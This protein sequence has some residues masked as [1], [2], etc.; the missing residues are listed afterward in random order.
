MSVDNIEK[1]YKYFDILESAKDKID[2]H[3]AE[4][5]AILE[6]VKGEQKEKRLAS[7]FI[8]RLFK[9]FPMYADMALG[10]QLN[11]CS[12]TDV[13]IR[14]QAT[15]DL[16]A[17]CKD[18]KEYTQKV[19]DILAQ[20]LQSKDSLELI[21]VQ[22]SLLAVLKSDPQG[23]FAGI[24]NQIL[25]GEDIV[26]ER[27]IK[28]LS[29]KIKQLG[30]DILTKDIEDQLIEN[31]KKVLQD[32][33]CEEFHTLMSILS[34]TRLG[35][36]VSGHKQLVDIVVEQSELDG[37]FEVNR[38]ED[39]HR[40]RLMQCL[41]IAMP[42]FSSQ[43][44]S[45]RFVAF[46]C[47]KVLPVFNQLTSSKDV[48]LNTSST[49]VQLDLLKA[50]SE[51][52]VHCHSLDIPEKRA[53]RV[54]NVLLDYMPIPP[55]CDTTT[56]SP[57]LQF[58]HVECLLY[59]YHSL[60]RMASKTTAVI[61]ESM[62]GEALKDFRVRLQYFARGVQAYI[63]I[64]KDALKGKTDAELKSEE[65][66]LKVAALRTTSNINILIKDLFHT[67]PSYKSQITLSWI[68][69]GSKRQRIV[70]PEYNTI[71][72][73]NFK[74]HTPITFESSPIK[75]TRNVA[76]SESR[77]QGSAYANGQ[78]MYIPPSG[79][80]STK[81][82]SYVPSNSFRGRGGRGNKPFE[83]AIFFQIDLQ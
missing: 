47:D 5:L 30:S 25:H 76:S 61:E 29:T 42:Y 52:M 63:K 41:A 73:S 10:A 18:N 11:L 39:D 43:V 14:K 65:N 74:R 27:C 31:C 36:A 82:T 49:E 38:E 45:S 40:E 44:D 66:Q 19:A 57:S 68:L 1:L 67:P 34:S 83:I 2:Q 69:P 28:F 37:N 53:Q 20:L 64:L 9:H 23:A 26:R 50:L 60:M 17:F 59:T 32:V 71:K 77:R 78:K 58:S 79:K 21:V 80:Y 56:E 6:A 7:Q 16:P 54:Y 62:Q 48:L 35:K 3:E 15:K 72:S 70:E 4:Y 12:D 22:N 24:F 8:A 51:L 46:I 13:A 75:R 33:T 81:V 55:D